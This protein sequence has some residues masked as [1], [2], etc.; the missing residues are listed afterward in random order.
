MRLK[1]LEGFSGLSTP[2]DETLEI[3]RELAR[4][5]SEGEGI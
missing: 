4:E 1:N 5:F 3:R 2:E